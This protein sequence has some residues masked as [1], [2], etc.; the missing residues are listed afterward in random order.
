MTELPEHLG[1]QFTR[2]D[3]ATAILLIVVVAML[4]D[5][6]PGL[7]VIAVGVVMLSLGKA[8]KST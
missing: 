1:H 4:L 6:S 5:V 7:A 3:V 2:T 8:T